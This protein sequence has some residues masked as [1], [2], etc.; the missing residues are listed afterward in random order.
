MNKKKNVLF[1]VQH[2]TLG[3]SQ[4]SLVSALNAL[5]YNKYDVSLYIRDNKLDLLSQINKN[6]NVILNIDTKKYN[7][8]LY[9]IFLLI[10]IKI[11]QFCGISNN[12]SK[13]QKK[14]IR[15]KKI[16]NEKKKYFKDAH[17]DVA[18]AYMQGYTAEFVDLAINATK[19]IVF[20]HGSIDEKHDIHEK[21]FHEFDYIVGVSDIVSGL[22]KKW[23]PY[24]ENK[25][26]V[27]ENYVDA[28]QI[29]IKSQEYVVSK[30]SNFVICTCGRLAQDK[31]FDRAINA[32]KILLDNNIDFYWY[33]IGDGPLKTE[34][35][36]SIET[37]G[38]NEKIELTGAK[39]NPFPY[40]V[41]SD[42]FVLCT[43]DEA[44]PM[45]IIE[46]KILNV[47]VI[48]TKTAGGL[49][50]IDDG[51]NGILVDFS[52]QSVA[53]GLIQYATKP[54]LL[55]KH[56]D[57]LTKINYSKRRLEYI[58]KINSLLDK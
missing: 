32:A 23:Y 43:D 41:A 15:Y 24:E 31:C 12:F 10:I 22:L 39:N 4:T 37:N 13:I 20:F 1:V 34:I 21:I 44:L 8:L 47:P 33:F 35:Q 38:L 48:S 14:Y 11:F 36:K 17:Y 6:V 28:D 16:E 54:E 45:T 42:V 51:N 52:S 56:K 7:L 26:K 46:S 19:K 2:L 53:E 49:S 3:G 57:N 9:S 30:K 18:I 25:I 58:N 27:L 50:L 55:R 29:R 40:F 5:D